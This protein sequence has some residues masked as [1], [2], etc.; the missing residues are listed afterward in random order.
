MTNLRD[1]ET[2]TALLNALVRTTDDEQQ[3][4]IYKFRKGS[5]IRGATAQ[6]VGDELETIKETAG[7]LTAGLVVNAARD[8]DHRLHSCFEWDDS[9]AAEEFRKTQAR[10][11]INCLIT[12]SREETGVQEYRQYIQIT[13]EK[14]RSYVS[15]V[16]ALSDAEIRQ[17]VLK[18][19]MKEANN[20]QDRYAHYQE[21]SSIFK[22]IE[23]TSV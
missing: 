3:A 6:V 15:T 5:R 7:I 11:L 19:A 1:M 21:L 9:V 10:H 14:T 16:E 20:W 23:D 18:K 22:A 8:P 13:R 4:A 17:Q 2:E 12:V